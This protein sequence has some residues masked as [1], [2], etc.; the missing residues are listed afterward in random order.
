MQTR[1]D[2][3]NC[4]ARCMGSEPP[5]CR[6]L[7]ASGILR[8]RIWKGSQAVPLF[9]PQQTHTLE[10]WWTLTCKD[11]L[12]YSAQHCQMTVPN[13]I[14]VFLGSLGEIGGPVWGV[15]KSP[16]FSA[17]NIAKETL[18]I[19]LT[20]CENGNC[21]GNGSLTL[22]TAWHLHVCSLFGTG[23]RCVNWIT[24]WMSIQFST[25][26]RHSLGQI[27]V[28]PA[29]QKLFSALLILAGTGKGNMISAS[30]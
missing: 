23:D 7:H 10:G 13:F 20:L 28:L 2:W 22:V 18:F 11:W 26:P 8:A 5:K 14:L 27:C 9:E 25:L 15:W 19:D 30:W 3:L 12:G 17:F 24:A 6:R 16:A 4:R 21:E 29:W 1:N